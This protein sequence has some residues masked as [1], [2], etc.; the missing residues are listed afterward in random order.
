MT[1]KRLHITLILI[2]LIPL[3]YYAGLNRGLNTGKTGAFVKQAIHEAYRQ[4]RE[5]ILVD[6][7]DGEIKVASNE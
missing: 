6:I 2:A 7:I 1:H 3:A 5:S 4:G